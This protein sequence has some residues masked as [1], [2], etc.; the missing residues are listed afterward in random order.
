[1]DLFTVNS[2]T[3]TQCGACVSSC[4]V[5]IIEI[6]K[7]NNAPSPVKGADSA[8]IVCGHCVAVCHEGALSHKKMPVDLCPP[9]QDNLALKPAHVEHLLRS[10]RSIRAYKRENVDK[11]TIL[12]LIDIVHYAPSGSNGQP[13]KWLVIYDREKVRKIAETV[14][15]WMKNTIEKHPPLAEK[16]YLHSLVALWDSGLDVVCREAPH[17]LFVHAPKE[18]GGALYDSI[19]A[20]SYLDI[21]AP[22]FELGTC[23]AGF[24]LLAAAYWPPLH[25]L[26]GLSDKE[27][28]FGAMMLGY[29]KHKF[30]RLPLRN[31]ADIAWN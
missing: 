21:A 12:K 10:R 9:F 7:G 15:D 3:C 24:V 16:L 18:K 28:I 22:S 5:G 8:C 23:W 17:I 19:I 14:I 11:Q 31:K 30:Y 6:Q 29:P 13:V 26:I 20:L 2:D 1:M 25:K 27:Q 4:P